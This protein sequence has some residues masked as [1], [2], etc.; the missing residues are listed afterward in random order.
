MQRP[1]PKAKKAITV[2]S[3]VVD[4]IANVA[5]DDIEKMTLH[6]STTSFLLM[7]PGRKLDAQ[8]IVT[9]TGGGAVNAA[10]SLSRQGY[11]VSALIKVGKDVNADKLLNRFKEEGISTDEVAVHE[12][13][14]TAISVIISSHGHNAAIFTHRGANGFLED[15]DVSAENFAGADL[16]YVTNLSN[17]SVSRF[18]KIVALAREAGAFVAVTP[19]ILQ[20]TNHT[21]EFFDNLLNVDLF[22]C[23]FKEAETLVPHLLERTGLEKSEAPEMPDE[24]ALLDHNGFRLGVGKYC[25]RLHQLG[26]Q[27][28]AV[29]N[30]ED[31]AFLSARGVLIHQPVILAQIAGTTGAGDSFASTL[32]GSLVQGNSPEKSMHFAALNAASVVGFSDAQTGLLSESELGV[33][34]DQDRFEV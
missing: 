2:G 13:E 6:N 24:N 20:L 29:T 33:K 12:S 17:N 23:N 27:F 15:E 11:N 14:L 25:D 5:D 7:E 4:I 16:V 9:H 3:A 8:S 1:L 32:A 28:I 34:Y 18:P 30:G 21:K 10:V 31:G 22:V 26:P 19:G